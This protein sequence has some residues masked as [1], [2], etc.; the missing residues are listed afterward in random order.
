MADQVDG[1]LFIASLI[2]A[3]IHRGIPEKPAGK[4]RDGL[5]AWFSGPQG[6]Q[7]LFAGRILPFDETAALIWGRLMAEGKARGRPRSGL[8]MIIAAVAQA[9]D[10]IVVTDNERD[11]EDIEILNPLRDAP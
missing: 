1:D 4:R 8:D 6:P 3:E 2:V 9:N 5:H 11:F 10:C 7:T